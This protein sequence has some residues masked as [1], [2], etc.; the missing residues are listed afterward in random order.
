M[1]RVSHDHKQFY[2]SRIRSLMIRNPAI[3]QRELQEGLEMEGL[4]LDRKYLGTL[5]N[6][7]Q[8]ERAK[9]ANKWTLN[10]ALAAFQDAMME[11]AK[12]GW[13]I[14]NDPMAR[15]MDK[16]LAMREI[17]EAQDTAFEKLFDA[18][19]FER[20]LGTLDATIRNTPLPEER[21]Q[22]IRSVFT[23]WGLLPAPQEDV[24]PA[25]PTA[26]T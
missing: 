19:V 18:G 21:K 10:Y 24:Q 8:A 23:N 11:I 13:E 16:A 5:V 20:K 17:R 25:E 3:T 4:R 15:N 12:A 9:R 14:V 2:K 22:A 7:I 26:N 6:G 1:P